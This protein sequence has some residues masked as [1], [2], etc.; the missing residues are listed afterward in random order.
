M[1]VA[2]RTR[3][4][5][6]PLVRGEEAKIVVARGIADFLD[7]IG[8]QL[9]FVDE[10]WITKQVAV[11]NLQLLAE[12]AGYVAE[13]G[14]DQVQLLLNVAFAPAEIAAPLAC[15]QPAAKPRPYQTPQATVDAFFYVV[16]QDDA[17]RLNRWLAD[18]PR[19]AAHLHKI[20]KS[21]HAVA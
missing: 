3:N 11:D 9:W 5:D 20:W 7:C 18:H 6:A 4:C 8:F 13:V 10:G 14:Q 1:A 21:R 17:D 2:A 12:Q 16:R 15:E 19:D